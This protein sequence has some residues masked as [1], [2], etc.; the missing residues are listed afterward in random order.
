MVVKIHLPPDDGNEGFIE[1]VEQKKIIKFIK[2]DS[3]IFLFFK[4]TIF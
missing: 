4:E 2:T 1:V 3:C